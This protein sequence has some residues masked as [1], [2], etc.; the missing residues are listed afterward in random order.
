M[1]GFSLIDKY[2]NDVFLSERILGENTTNI[3]KI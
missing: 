1:F 2:L 3:E